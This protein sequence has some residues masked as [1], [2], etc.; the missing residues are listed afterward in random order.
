MEFEGQNRGEQEEIV[1]DLS[2]KSR[3][4]LIMVKVRGQI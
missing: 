3:E 1:L 2:Q 4:I